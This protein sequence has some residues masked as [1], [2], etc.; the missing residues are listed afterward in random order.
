MFV[1]LWSFVDVFI[2]PSTILPFLPLSLIQW[3]PTGRG[4]P[5]L[6]QFVNGIAVFGFSSPA[7]AYMQTNFY[8][9][10]AKARNSLS[11]INSFFMIFKCDRL[12]TVSTRR[13][14]GAPSAPVPGL[15]LAVIPL[16]DPTCSLFQKSTFIDSSFS[17]KRFWKVGNHVSE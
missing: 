8:I 14:A 9:R 7:L 1:Y 12:S 3:R 11:R 15:T 4:R 6:L 13:G 5:I 2:S 17:P 16:L 10:C